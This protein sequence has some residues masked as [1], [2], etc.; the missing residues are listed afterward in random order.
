MP[1]LVLFA[2]FALPRRGG[3]ALY[4]LTGVS[5]G[6]LYFALDNLLAALGNG[7]VLTPFVAAFGALIVF[8]VTGLYIFTALEAPGPTLDPASPSPSS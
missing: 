6:F 4:L 5:A 2:G 8:T 1:L 7:G 3:T